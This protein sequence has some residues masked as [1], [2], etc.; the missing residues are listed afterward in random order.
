[1]GH[2]GPAVRLCVIGAFSIGLVIVPVA[3]LLAYATSL[4]P[5]GTA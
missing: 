5:A 4:T 2:G 3:A 1:M